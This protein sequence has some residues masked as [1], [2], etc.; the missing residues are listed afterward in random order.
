MSTFQPEN[1]TTAYNVTNRTNSNVL[2]T[3]P[4]TDTVTETTGSHLSTQLT[5]SK[6]KTVNGRTTISTTTKT[7]DTTFTSETST[8][9]IKQNGTMTGD[10]MS[11]PPNISTQSVVTNVTSSKMSHPVTHTSS[12]KEKSTPNYTST[13]F[14]LSKFTEYLLLK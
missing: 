4:G 10:I 9:R 6:I 14:P 1:E 8:V 3:S 11:T 13:K 2:I 7:S 5:E 12:T